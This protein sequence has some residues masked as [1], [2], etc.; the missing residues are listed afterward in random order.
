MLATTRRANVNPTSAIPAQ[1]SVCA[2]SLNLDRTKLSRLSVCASDSDVAESTKRPSPFVVDVGPALKVPDYG[3]LSAQPQGLWRIATA[4]LRVKT[5]GK[6][7]AGMF[8]D[9]VACNLHNATGKRRESECVPG[10]RRFATTIWR[11]RQTAVILNRYT[12]S[13]PSSRKRAFDWITARAFPSDQG[14]GGSCR[15]LQM[16]FR[17]GGVEARPQQESP[18][19][20][21]IG[22]S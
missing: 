6:I 3:R 17:A 19:D 18:F 11:H 22:R 20:C 13:V 7:V 21:D 1:A 14:Y 4:A 16:A 8:G 10:P 2:G 9:P 15:A 5:G 12:A